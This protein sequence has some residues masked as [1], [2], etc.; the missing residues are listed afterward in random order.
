MLRAL[1]HRNYRLFFSG[2]TVSTVGT[3]M[4]TIAMNWLVYKL[5]DSAFMLGALNF[6][7]HVPGFLLGPVAGVVADRY[8]R[9]KILIIT[10]SLA[11]VQA[12]LLAILVLTGKIAV[13]HLLGLGFALGCINAFDLTAR[14]AFVVDMVEERSDLPNAI[15]LNS[16]ILSGSK[17][18]GPS[19]AGILIALV[20]EGVCFLINAVSFIPVLAALLAMRVQAPVNGIKTGNSPWREMHEGYL[21]AYR[22]PPICYTVLLLGLVNLTGT[23]YV[24]LMP[25][26]AHNIFTG[27]SHTLGL[28]MA[29][30]GLGAICGAAF[31]ASRISPAGLEKLIPRAVALLG[32][33]LLVFSQTNVLF[34]G[35]ITLFFTGLGSMVHIAASSTLMQSLV[36]EDKR[37]RIMSL[38]SM[39]FGMTPFGNL[40]AGIMASYIGAAA[41]VGIGG[42]LCVVG[43]MLYVSRLREIERYTKTKDK[44]LERVSEEGDLTTAPKCLARR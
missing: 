14:Q 20:G 44:A 40:L 24:A 31:L 1:R 9:H 29:V 21:Y 8:N 26:F 30:T 10:Q 3:W 17:L 43:A 13:W 23:A 28:L 25:I 36:E 19:M 5:T 22:F 39:S 12:A 37:G 38:Y 35:L 32:I 11:M 27:D 15:A 7:N 16:I 34:V 4:Q 42:L 33:T 41:T 18:V 6:F 2:Q